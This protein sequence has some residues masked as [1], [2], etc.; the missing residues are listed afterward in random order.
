VDSGFGGLRLVSFVEDRYGI[1]VEAHEA[2]VENF[3]RI[4]SIA[5]FIRD[6]G[7]ASG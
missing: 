2:G 7:G 1:E 3:D 5:S 4:D 6:K